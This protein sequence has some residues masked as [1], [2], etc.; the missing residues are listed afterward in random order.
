M[1]TCMVGYGSV[2]AQGMLQHRSLLY[3]SHAIP[4]TY[5]NLP[6]DRTGMDKVD[7]RK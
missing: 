4:Y 3:H 2:S 5:S 7:N 6:Y 1:G